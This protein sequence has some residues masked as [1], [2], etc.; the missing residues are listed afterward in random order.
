MYED[1]IYANL[2]TRDLMVPL[3]HV[4]GYAFYMRGWCPENHADGG[5]GIVGNGI[6]WTTAGWHGLRAFVT[7][8]ARALESS[9][10]I[11]LDR[12]ENRRLRLQ[13]PTPVIGIGCSMLSLENLYHCQA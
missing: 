12:Q 11:A 4:L 8:R 9:R 10:N 1:R 5:G 13:S 6:D 7:W 3:R 2:Y